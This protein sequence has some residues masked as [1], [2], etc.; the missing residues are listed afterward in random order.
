MPKV[1]LNDMLGVLKDH[2]S[3]GKDRQESDAPG[4]LQIYNNLAAAA[5][6]PDFL[7]AFETGGGA[8]QGC[9][10]RS[11]ACT[12]R[13]RNR[14]ALLRAPEA[15]DTTNPDSDSG[16]TTPGHTT[17]GQGPEQGDSS[18]VLSDSRH[19]PQGRR[20]CNGA[21]PCQRRPEIAPS[22]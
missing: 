3:Q 21:E 7:R 5:E 14:E 19:P 22:T 2:A 12:C 4:A 18:P 8:K 11:S 20:S 13:P 17:A 1:T 6:R 10:R 15:T 9:G 16:R